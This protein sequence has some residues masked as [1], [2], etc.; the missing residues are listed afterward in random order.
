MNTDCTG[1]WF[2]HI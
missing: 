1:T 2:V